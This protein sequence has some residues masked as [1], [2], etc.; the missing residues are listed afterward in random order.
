MKHFAYFSYAR[1]PLYVSPQPLASRLGATR[2]SSPC[3]MRK[4][5]SFCAHLRNG[6]FCPQQARRQHPRHPLGQ[7]PQRQ[8][9]LRAPRQKLHTS[10]LTQW[11][12]IWRLRI[13][14]TPLRLPSQRPPLR[15]CRKP[16][17]PQPLKPKRVRPLSPNP[18]PRR[19]KSVARLRDA[20]GA[21]LSQRT[22]EYPAPQPALRKQCAPSFRT[23]LESGNAS[24]LAW[25]SA[26]CHP[27]QA[28][29]A[30]SNCS[31]GWRRDIRSC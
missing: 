22:A 28:K 27:C 12:R 4:S 19:S 24:M 6:R 10:F 17:R 21:F 20:Q 9:P 15:C 7:V 31:S 2:C 5:A 26:S 18:R 14:G 23:G 25:H 13:T 30:T 1:A 11:V 8:L 29:D 16:H 3:R